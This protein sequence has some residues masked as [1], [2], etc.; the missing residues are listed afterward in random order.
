MLCFHEKILILGTIASIFDMVFVTQSV[1]LKTNITRW[2]YI[3]PPVMMLPIS[4]TM[5]REVMES[6]IGDCHTTYTVAS[7]PPAVIW[8]FFRKSFRK[9]KLP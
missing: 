4:F 5:T 9:T 7:L 6:V 2:L 8:G 3:T 1:S